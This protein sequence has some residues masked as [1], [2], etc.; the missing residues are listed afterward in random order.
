LTVRASQVGA[1]ATARRASRS[2]ADRIA[3]SLDLLRDPAFDVL[4]TGESC[5]DDLPATMAQLASGEL[6]A[7]C[8]L[9]TYPGG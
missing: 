4:I 3:L 7:L 1:I 6:P 9:V 8:H 2:F 5:F